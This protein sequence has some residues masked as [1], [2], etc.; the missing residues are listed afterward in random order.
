MKNDYIFLPSYDLPSTLE[1][2]FIDWPEVLSCFLE[3]IVSHPEF[4]V[5][6]AYAQYTS[7]SQEIFI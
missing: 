2:F 3:M 7:T 4:P 1:H 5:L 6:I